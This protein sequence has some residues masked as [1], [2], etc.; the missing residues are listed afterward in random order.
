MMATNEKHQEA[1]SVPVEPRGFGKR[2]RGLGAEY[3]H[4]QGW[5]LDVDERTKIPH[6]PENARGKEYD[7][8]AR[9]FGDEPRNTE[10]TQSEVPQNT[11]V[12]SSNHT[13]KTNP[14]EA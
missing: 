2:S 10:D 4:E 5:G 1:S 13:G 9:D 8:G 11:P 12:S 14:D 3:A 6:S 7:Y